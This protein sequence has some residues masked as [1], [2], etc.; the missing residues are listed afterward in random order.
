MTDNIDAFK[1]WAIVELFGRVVLAGEVTEQVIAGQGFVRVD[2]PGNAKT[3][4]HTKYFGPNAIY[5]ITPT[6]EEIALR[7]AI[8]SVGPAIPY[9]ISAR[10][11]II[12]D[13]D[14][15]LDEEN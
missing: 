12:D 13:E 7:T 14:D 2:V 1:C 5:A 3:P 6:T 4:A 15:F 10:I 8:L 9:S 11:N